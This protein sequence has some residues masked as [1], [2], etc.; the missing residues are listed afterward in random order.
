[1]KPDT[2]TS[3]VLDRFLSMNWLASPWAVAIAGGLWFA[4]TAVISLPLLDAAFRRGPQ[5]YGEISQLGRLAFIHFAL[6]SFMAGMAFA[7]HIVFVSSPWLS[8][9]LGALLVVLANIGT[10]ANTALLVEGWNHFGTA[11]IVTAVMYFIVDVVAFRGIPFLIGG[12]SA[13]LF[14]GAMRFYFESYDDPNP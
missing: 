14:R 6:P 10:A 3:G 4:V 5:A 9:W 13:V 7:N 12:V 11:S 1:M 2:K 8:F